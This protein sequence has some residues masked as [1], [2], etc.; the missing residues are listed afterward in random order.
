MRHTEI[1]ALASEVRELRIC[2]GDIL[3]L[4]RGTLLNDGRVVTVYT[5]Y[6]LLDLEVVD[7]VMCVLRWTVLTLAASKLMAM[8]GWGLHAPSVVDRWDGSA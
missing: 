1:A 7:R 8:G 5:W 2:V 6:L 4:V 3:G